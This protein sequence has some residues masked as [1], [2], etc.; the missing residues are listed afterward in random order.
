MYSSCHL[1]SSICIN[2]SVY[3]IFKFQERES[4]VS[5]VHKY[6]LYINKYLHLV[7]VETIMQY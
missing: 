1:Y 6:A 7:F 5:L 4:I 2:I 3:K